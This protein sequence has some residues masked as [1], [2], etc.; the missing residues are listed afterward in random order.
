MPRMLPAP[1][2]TGYI[3]CLI[4]YYITD[5]RQ[6]RGDE[7]ARTLAL[8]DRITAAVR[9]GVDYIQLR[10]KDLTACHLESLARGAMQRIQGTRTRLLINARVDVAIACGA[11]GVHLPANDISPA[12]ARRIFAAA[13]VPAP[14]V[15]V[16]CHSVE[17]VRTAESDGA[18]F[19][20]FG[21]V[22]E[23]DGHPGGGTELLRYACC[24]QRIP[25]VALGGVTQEN[26]AVCTAAGAT[27]IAGIRL[28]QSDDVETC[29]PRL[30]TLL[31]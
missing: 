26:A 28:F 15:A 27:G 18:D 11:H 12:E 7:A 24:G 30:R 31:P 1:V 5:R 10:E 21:P 13:G 17:E 25:V 6:C 20:V 29:V 23:K 14:T 22:F 2:S 8:F 19:V 3:G 16:S 4:L 9:A